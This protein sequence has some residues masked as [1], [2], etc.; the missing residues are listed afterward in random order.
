MQVLSQNIQNFLHKAE[1]VTDFPFVK[2]AHRRS[3]ASPL[4]LPFVA[5]CFSRCAPT[6]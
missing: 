2:F 4:S 5:S 6:N 3:L 1:M